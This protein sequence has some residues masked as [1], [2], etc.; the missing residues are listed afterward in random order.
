MVMYDP[1]PPTPREIEE[2]RTWLGLVYCGEF[3][4]G[5]DCLCPECRT[6]DPDREDYPGATWEDE[7][8]RAGT[9]FLSGLA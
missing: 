3:D 6:P 8:D 2:W 4:C 1:D 7:D 5:L 9:D